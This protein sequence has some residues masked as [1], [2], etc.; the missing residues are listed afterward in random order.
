MV[1]AGMNAG[2]LGKPL[3]TVTLN[4]GDPKPLLWSTFGWDGS[5]LGGLLNRCDT[6]L[7]NC[8]VAIRQEGKPYFQCLKKFFIE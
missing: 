2:L 7:D 4:A 5:A 3:A 1:R 6:P 8:L